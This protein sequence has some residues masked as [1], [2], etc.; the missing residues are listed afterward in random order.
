MAIDPHAHA[1][2]P[3]TGARKKGG[4]AGRALTG[5]LWVL[6]CAGQSA[7]EGADPLSGAGDPDVLVGT[8][9]VKLSLV[10]GS[11][12]PTSAVLGKVYDGAT[13]ATVVW[14]SPV[15]DGECTLTTPRVPFCSP[16]CGGSAACVEDDVCEP[17]PSAR[18]VGAVS[19]SGLHASDGRASFVMTPIANAYQPPAGVALD[20]PP[21]GEGEPVT[22]SATGEYFAAFSIESRGLLP[23]D[24]TSPDI[25]LRRG[26]PVELGWVPGAPDNASVHVKLDISHHGGSKGQIECDTS[27]SGALTISAELI[28]KLIDLGISG[29]PT[30][31]VTRWAFG[32]AVIAAGR[33][34][35]EVSSVVEREIGVEGLTSCTADAQCPR[36]QSCQSDSSCR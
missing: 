14:E 9:Q 22:F 10:P 36:G 18:S 13:P 17:Y 30:V 2:P 32:S 1:H 8:F 4:A 28:T 31:I 7:R 5:S 25:T 12:A 15:I 6:A 19:V 21:F 33:V 35:L 34:D 3:S 23:L 11:T 26:E 29:Y 24:L 27:D 20:Y 16:L